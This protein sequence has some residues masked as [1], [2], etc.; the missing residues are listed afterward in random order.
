MPANPIE[1][2]RKGGQSRSEK[3]VA[4]ARRN[5]FQKVKPVAPAAP[6]EPLP[7]TRPTLLVP[8]V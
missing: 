5:G 7:C 2:G 8:K 6:A 1:A 4:A 3:K